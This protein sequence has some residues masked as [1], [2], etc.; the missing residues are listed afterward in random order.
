M[1]NRTESNLKEHLSQDIA[2]KTLI[3]ITHRASLLDLVDRIIII[4]NASITA[5]G[6][7]E[8]VLGAIRSG[9]IKL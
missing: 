8:V 3:L 4:D 5:D 6:P 7:R 9:Q 1:D 2:E